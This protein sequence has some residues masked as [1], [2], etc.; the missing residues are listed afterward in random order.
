[1]ALERR[2]FLS[3]LTMTPFAAV[4]SILK[5]QSKKLCCEAFAWLRR[6]ANLVI[7]LFSLMLKVS[8][9]FTVFVVCK[10]FP[11]QANQSC[12]LKAGITIG[13]EKRLDHADDLV[14]VTVCSLPESLPG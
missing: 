4:Y 11:T 1:M 9:D 12:A 5:P 3:F 10:G 6:R 2:G 8:S 7:T 13:R 14:K